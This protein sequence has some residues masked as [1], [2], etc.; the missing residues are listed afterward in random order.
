MSAPTAR[1]GAAEKRIATFVMPIVMF[2]R[3]QI[4][5]KAENHTCHCEEARSADVAIRSPGIV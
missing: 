1:Q 5:A 4:G 3:V 2:E